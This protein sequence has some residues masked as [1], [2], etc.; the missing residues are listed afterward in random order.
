MKNLAGHPKCDHFIKKEL[1]EAGIPIVRSDVP[2]KSEVASKLSGKLG[3]FEF[4][5]AW[6]YWVV[7]GDVPLRVAEDIYRGPIGKRDIRVAGHAGCPPPNEWAFP[8]TEVLYELGVYKHPSEDLPFGDSPTYGDLAKMCNSGQIDA[9]RFVS[10]YHIDSQVG[11]N[12][13]VKTIKSYGLVKE[14]E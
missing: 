9:P 2:Q 6:R 4:Y 12:M 14:L 3:E 5:R 13:F 7:V 10:S 11:L 1:I 8:K